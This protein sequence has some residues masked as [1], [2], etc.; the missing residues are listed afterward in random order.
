MDTPTRNCRVK[1]FA[2]RLALEFANVFVGT[3]M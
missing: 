2:L 1:G 3:E